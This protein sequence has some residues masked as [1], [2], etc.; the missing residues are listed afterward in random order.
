MA[1]LSV[2]SL[3]GFGALI[4]VC[5]VVICSYYAGM[6]ED[7]MLAPQTG[8]VVLHEVAG[9]VWYRSSLQEWLSMIPVI[10]FSYQGHI[11][12]VPLYAE[13]KCRSMK[14]WTAVISLGL[15]ACVVLYNL[16]G[17]LG[18]LQFLE[19]TDADVLKSLVQNQAALNIPVSWV[20]AARV[21]VAIAVAVTFAVFTFCARSAIF[22][23]LSIYRGDKMGSS[24]SGV[25]FL[26]V[27]YAWIAAVAVAA[28][29]VP[30]MG[31]VVSVVGNV[32]T[33]FMFQFPGLCLIA[34]AH[35]GVIDAKNNLQWRKFFN[36][37]GLPAAQLRKALFGWLFVILGTLIFTLGLSN[38]L[39]SLM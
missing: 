16:A 25:H 23:E 22:N 6:D 13:L 14:R 21:A 36:C 31:V 33:F 37:S 24:Q 18:Y 29:L 19:K 32:S 7:A 3:V 30:D 2:P 11:S 9:P 27:T 15:G 20:V 12:A 10:V 5:L 17:I 8:A 26:A 1:S 28:I 35:G 4:Y 34:S 38:A 39:Y